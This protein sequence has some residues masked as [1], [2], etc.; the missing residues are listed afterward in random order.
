MFIA[1]KKITVHTFLASGLLKV[2]E[3]KN[4]SMNKHIE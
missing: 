1:K 3:T 2:K 4:Y